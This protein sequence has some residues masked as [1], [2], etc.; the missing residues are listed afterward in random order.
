MATKYNGKWISFEGISGVGKT[1]F[2]KKIKEKLANNPSLV[3]V[4]EIFDSK[5][6]VMS[7]MI[8]EALYY[9]NDRFF[10]MD[11][12]L[13]ETMLLLSNSMLKYE[14]II[15]PAL[16]NGKIVIEDRGI[17]T[18]ALY[19]AILICRKSNTYL[20]LT[21]IIDKIY[22]FTSLYSRI[23]DRTFLFQGI[24]EKVLASAEQR[25]SLKYT[26]KQ[27]KLFASG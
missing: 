12:P 8:F 11:I 21:N 20:N 3:F 13:T 7:K 16:C 2:F 17:D 10:D 1:Y 26:E 19:Q 24:F 14:T 25:D 5:R 27:K 22:N 18:I 9:T 6:V 4:D 23:P 15:H